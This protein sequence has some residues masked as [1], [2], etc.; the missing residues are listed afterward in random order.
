LPKYFFTLF[1]RF[2][3]AFSGAL[4]FLV[5]SKLFGANGRGVI[6]FGTSLVSILAFI[7]SLNLGRYFLLATKKNNYLQKTLLPDFISFN[8]III[9]FCSFI[10]FFIWSLSAK[11]KEIISF[12]LICAFILLIPYYIWQVNGIIFSALNKTFTQDKVIFFIRLLLLIFLVIIYFGNFSFTFF[13][14]IYSFILSF[15]VFIEINILGSSTSLFSINFPKL[16]LKST[17]SYHIDYLAVYLYPLLLM[18]LCGYMIEITDLGKFNFLI[19]LNSFIF[20][21]SFVASLKIKS[22]VSIK[23][24]KFFYIPA[25]KIFLFTIFSSAICVL[26]I[27]IFLRTNL[28]SIYLP[29]FS[30]LSDSFALMSTAIPGFFIYQCLYPILIEIEKNR[31]S[32]YFNSLIFVISLLLSYYLIG[33]YGFYGAIYSYITFYILLFFT[34]LLLMFKIHHFFKY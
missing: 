22:Y 29:D 16:I 34:Q 15:G 12:E 19:Q 26:S 1:V 30:N 32:A 24:I 9:I 13:L 25:L 20:I 11:S 14:L 18:L 31:L 23:G 10:V 28:I 6:A 17:L 5:T 33:S 4:V 7:F 2:F 3:I 27:W 8:F 21:L